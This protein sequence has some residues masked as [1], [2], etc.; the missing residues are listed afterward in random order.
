MKYSFIFSIII[1]MCWCSFSDAMEQTKV[2]SDGNKEIII[3]ID[4]LEK[5]LHDVQ[6]N[7]HIQHKPEEIR[8][9]MTL[10]EFL[11]LQKKS[12]QAQISIPEG[13]QSSS[14]APTLEQSISNLQNGVQALKDGKPY[15]AWHYVAG[16][17]SV[18][19]TLASLAGV[20]ITIILLIK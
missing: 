3:R 6:Q 5:K 16:G 2:E 11:E 19:A 14:N 9:I 7:Q 12:Q 8:I 15:N 13:Q 10:P 4:Q 1:T 18:T 20:I 17:G